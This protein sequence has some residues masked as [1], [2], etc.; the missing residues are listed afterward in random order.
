MESLLLIF[1]LPTVGNA[2][3]ISNGEQL[4]R[5]EGNISLLTDNT[6]PH[7]SNAET[8]FT[9][10][11][12]ERGERPNSMSNGTMHS[13]NVQTIFTEGEL[14]RR[15]PQLNAFLS[16]GTRSLI[17]PVF[18]ITCNYNPA[19]SI[20]ASQERRDRMLLDNEVGQTDNSGTVFNV[21]QLTRS[22]CQTNCFSYNSVTQVYDVA[23][24]VIEEQPL[25]RE[26]CNNAFCDDSMTYVYDVESIITEVEQRM[27]ES[28]L[29]VFSDNS[30]TRADDIQTV[31]TE[32]Q[33]ERY[34]RDI[35]FNEKCY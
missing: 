20:R 7:T 1:L 4:G 9:E 24:A 28:C 5:G 35:I 16:N 31:F 33:I 3:A 8:V 23:Q 19:M 12:I 6:I 2:E 34:E 11:Q 21:E 30:V 14:A 29:T 32:E 25:R 10:E 17:F 13:Y 15:D 27:R 26:S 18:L 22:E